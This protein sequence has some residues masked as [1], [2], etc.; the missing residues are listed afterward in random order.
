MIDCE[1]FR[2]I[3]TIGFYSIFITLE[4]ICTS[5][6]IDNKESIKNILKNE[7][8]RTQ[9]N[10]DK[11]NTFDDGVLYENTF[12][13]LIMLSIMIGVAL[14]N[15]INY[16]KNS[17]KVT[18]EEE[19]KPLLNIIKIDRIELTFNIILIMSIIGVFVLNITQLIFQLYNVSTKCIELIDNNINGFMIVYSLLECCCTLVIISLVF[20]FAFYK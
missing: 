18:Y 12:A 10:S 11:I 1:Y 9:C 5:F 2:N 6:L 15:I 14:I 4:L 7:T 3:L 17:K 16:R 8:F 19:S 20:I 13:F